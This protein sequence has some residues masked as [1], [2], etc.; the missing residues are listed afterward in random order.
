MTDKFNEGFFSSHVLFT[1]EEKNPSLNL[2]VKV[3][4]EVKNVFIKKLVK[5]TQQKD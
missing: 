3:R 4:D 2:S 5:K 1:C